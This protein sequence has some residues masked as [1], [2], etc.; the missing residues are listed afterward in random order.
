M[1]YL[2]RN[3]VYNDTHRSK[4]VIVPQKFTKGQHQSSFP[5]QFNHE[6]SNKKKNPLPTKNIEIVAKLHYEI[7]AD[8]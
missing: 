8:S 3:K 5:A 4:T 2:G 6:P 1:Q 7:S